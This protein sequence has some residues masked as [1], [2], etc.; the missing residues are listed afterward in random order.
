V[1]RPLLEVEGLAR[2]FGGLRAVDGLSFIVPEG[3]VLG[4]VGPNGSGKTTA[5]NL[6][7]GN[8][9]PDAGRVLFAAQDIA[10][11]PAHKVA[12]AGVARTFQLVRV[13]ASMTIAENVALGAIFGADACTPTEALRRAPE[14]LAR[15][16]LAGRGPEPAGSLTYIDQK[17]L[18]L[19]RALAGRPRL[20]L[21]DEWLA[22]LNPT[23][24]H[25]GIALI[26]SLALEGITIVMVEHVMSAIR[27]LCGHVVVMNAGRRI[28]EGTP[29]EALSDPAVIAA[30]LGDDADAPFAEHADA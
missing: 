4:L 16:G 20:L 13:M 21:L 19:A 12:R 5:L 23:E 14:L 27:A 15:V 30:Y 26:R 2:R 28:A 10:G 8:L 11:A 29:D 6:I 7:T 18:E 17:R 9:R 24:L 22:G 3:E 25:E 1:K